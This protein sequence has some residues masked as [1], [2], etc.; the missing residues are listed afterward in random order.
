MEHV[1]TMANL[2][3]K[4]S[5]LPSHPTEH[6]AIIPSGLHINRYFTI[7]VYNNKQEHFVASEK[8]LTTL[9]SVKKKL[10]KK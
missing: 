8:W 4:P 7:I 6:G 10:L 9:F 1:L 5:L 2:K 3:L